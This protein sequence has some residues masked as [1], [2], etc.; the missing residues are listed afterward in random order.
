M[1]ITII[2]KAFEALCHQFRAEIQ[3]FEITEINE[4]LNL[5]P[6]IRLFEVPHQVMGNFHNNYSVRDNLL[7]GQKYFPNWF[8]NRLMF[9]QARIKIIAPYI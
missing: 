2:K 9:R 6:R 1:T 5:F 7:I 8:T 4:V 3:D